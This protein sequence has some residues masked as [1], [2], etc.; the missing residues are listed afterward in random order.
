MGEESIAP[1]R[2]MSNR[3]GRAA[4]VDNPPT[5]GTMDAARDPSRV[6]EDAVDGFVKTLADR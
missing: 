5:S 1:V 3:A 4:A 2:E 6:A